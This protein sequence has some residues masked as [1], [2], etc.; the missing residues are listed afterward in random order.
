MQWAV[1]QLNLGNASTISARTA[2]DAD[3]AP[4]G[5]SRPPISAALDGL[6]AR[7]VAPLDWASVQNNL[8]SV[9]QTHRPAHER[10]G[11]ARGIRRRVPRRTGGIYPREACRS[12]GRWRR[13]ISATR[14]SLRANSRTIRQS[15]QRSGRTP[16]APR[17][18]SS[19]RRLADA[20]GAGAD[21][22]RFGARGPRI[23]RTETA[24]LIAAAAA[25]R[26]A[27]EVITRENSP[28]EW[29]TTQ[30]AIGTTLVQLGNREPNKARFEEANIAF[31]A[32]HRHQA[33][34]PAAAMGLHPEQY[35]RCAL[36]ARHARRLEKDLEIAIAS[37]ET[38]KSGF[39]EA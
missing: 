24:N 32:A 5:G 4:R 37:Y 2:R 22:P 15:A 31:E 10:S 6:H 20:V 12:T 33:R 16:I 17:S 27:L 19:A 25:R 30:N 13:T 21:E 3:G 34:G 35:R 26:A 28:L 11:E 18:A 9:L 23:S 38:A 8:G 39:Q 7:K 29:A 36:V 1:S 14:C